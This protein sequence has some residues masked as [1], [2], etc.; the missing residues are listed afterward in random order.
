ALEQIDYPTAKLDIKFIIEEDDDETF[1]ALRK[2]VRRFGYEVIVAPNGTPRTKPRALN[3][4]LP[5]L[6]GEFVSI[7]DA[8]DLPDILQLR[9]AAERFAGA[10][11]SVACLQARL[12]IDNLE[13]WLPRLFAIEYAALFDVINIGFADFKLPFP[14]GGSSNHF[15]TD[16]LRKIGGWDAWNVTED[17][18]IGFRMARFGYDCA[19]FDSTTYEEAPTRIGAFLGQRRRWCKGWYQTLFTLCRN[20]RR[21]LREVGARRAAAMVVILL[22]S[23]LAP[24]CAPLAFIL[25][26]VM[27]AEGGF[28][29][30]STTF[31][32]IAATLW[33]SVF[34][35]GIAAILWPILAGMKRRGLLALWPNLLLLPF[36]YGLIS[37]AA[38]TSLYDLMVRPYYWYKTEHGLA[39]A[40]RRRSRTRNV[41]WSGYL[42]RIA[43]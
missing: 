6:R 2:S 16:I 24:L 22:S 9:D 37:A 8:E 34:V 30:P 3:V 7:F 27:L 28:F 26:A 19:T 13:G 1:A 31:E 43:S 38:W 39:K 42:D 32:I 12:A 33:T 5:L 41:D 4:A 14:L 23:V 18:D 25:F 21:L 36:Y 10:A 11:P 35:G 17:A 29:W 20:P 40:R 15:R